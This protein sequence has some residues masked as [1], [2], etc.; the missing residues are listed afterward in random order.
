MK[1][2]SIIL[3]LC[4]LLANAQNLKEFERKV[5]EFTLPNGL[6]FTV[7]ERHEAPV[8]SFHT[9]VNAGAV[10]DPEG[11]T[12]LAH[13]FEHMA[14]KG[15]PTIGTKNWA[16]E[17]KALEEVERAYDVLEAARNEERNK[18]DADRTR[19]P[20]LEAALK[21]AIEKASSYVE[22]NLY[23]RIIEESGGVGLNAGTAED[24]T[25]YFYNLPE[26][27]ME[28]WF[29]L[30]SARFLH[31]VFRDFYKERDVVREERRMRTES[32]PQGKLMETFQATA[33]MAHPYRRPPVGWASDIEN[34]RMG[35][36]EAFFNKYYVPG[37]INIA[38][39]GDVKP[40]EVRRLAE[41]YFGPIAKKPLPSPVVTVEP[42]QDGPK[43]AQVESPSQ[44]IEFIGYKRPDQHD[45][46]DA[47][48][49]V[50]SG[51]LSSGRTGLLYRELVRD[52]KL[53]LAAGADAAFP[54]TKYPGLFLFYLVPS[55]GKTLPE[56]E[57]AFYGVID[58]LRKDPIDAQTLAR[59]K[60]KTRANLIRQLDSNSGLARLLTSAYANYGDW[61]KIFTDLEDVEKVTA[62]DVQRVAN[63]YFTDKSRTSGFLFQGAQ[64]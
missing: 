48:F 57:K 13:M 35:D 62:Q 26:N 14:F 7:C 52:Q 63:Q 5:T 33:I 1:R 17:K 29:L 30:E 12:G 51:I 31:P 28:L 20:Q 46:D 44:P 36:A 43:M 55:L 23:P 38:I 42:P 54:G 49:D 60:T 27:K 11:K 10:D 50:I 18:P 25:E 45:K 21:A 53:A 41:K 58:R 16:L 4:P 9:Y 19:I 15:T 40:A 59:V 39:V 3:A 47:V 61:R 32:D 64:K 22:P 24:S 8:I 56:N 37:N 34:L 6:H 2:F